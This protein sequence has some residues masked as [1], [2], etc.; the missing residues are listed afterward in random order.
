MFALILFIIIPAPP[1]GRPRTRLLGCGAER[2]GLLSA[3]AVA[4]DSTL[5]N[6]ETV[7]GGPAVGLK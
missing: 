7:S 3:A 1:L 2:V 6:V 5:E 4:L